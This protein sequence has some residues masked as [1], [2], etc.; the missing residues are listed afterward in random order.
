MDETRKNC[1]IGT[2]CS[3]V[4]LLVAISLLLGVCGYC[5]PSMRNWTQSVIAGAEDSPVREAF[6]VLSEGLEDG[7]PLKD[8]AQAS[9]S[10]LIGHEA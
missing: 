4:Y 6:H 9:L 1:W 8:A 2:L 5:Y 7:V 10:V 3:F